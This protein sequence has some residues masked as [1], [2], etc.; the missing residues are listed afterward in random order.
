M[1][2]KNMHM[3]FMQFFMRVFIFETVFFRMEI[4]GA[5]HESCSKFIK[6]QHD[7]NFNEKQSMCI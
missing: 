4:G 3:F 7:E 5:A 2:H 6:A 1:Q